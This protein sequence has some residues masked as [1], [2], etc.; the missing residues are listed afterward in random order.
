[1]QILKLA[2]E[3]TKSYNEAKFEF[4][5][6]TNAIV[7]ANGAGKSTILEAIGFALFDSMNYRQADFVREGA[8]T[9]TVTVT[10]LS[11][12]DERRYEITRRCGGSNQYYVFD[13]ELNGKIC[14]G[15]SDV[16]TFLKEHM[17]VDPAADLTALFTDAVGVPQGT[18]TAAFLQAASARKKAFDTLLQ[19]EEYKEAADKLRE[20][21]RILRDQIQT[22]DL[23][24]KEIE[25]RLERL[26]ELQTQVAARAKRLAELE[27]QQS[28]YKTQLDTLQVRIEAESAIQKEIILAQEEGRQLTQRLSSL[29]RE[30]KG[31]REALSEAEQSQQLVL[32]NQ[33]G[34]EAYQ[35]AQNEQTA[36]G[37]QQQERQK[38]EVKQNQ[39]SQVIARVEMEIEV[40]SRTL[41]EIEAAQQLVTDLAEAVQQQEKLEKEQEALERKRIQLTD[42]QRDLP[43][44]EK[45]LSQ[46]QH[47]QNKLETQLAGQ[48]DLAEKR[49]RLNDHLKVQQDRLPQFS[50]AMG[51]YQVEA[52]SLKEQVSSLQNVDTAACPVCE[53]PLSASHRQALMQRNEARLKELRQA[54]ST[55]RKE[56]EEAKTQLEAGQSQ[57][58][59]LDL[60]LR[61]LPRP[62]ELQTVRTEAH[63]CTDHLNRQQSQIETLEGE[64]P[65]LERTQKSLEELGNPRQ[66]QAL[67]LDKISQREQVNQLLGKLSAKKENESK[68]RT[69]VADQLQA[70]SGLDQAIGSV[71]ETLARS[72]SA[73]QAVLAHQQ[74]AASLDLR[75]QNVITLQEEEESLQSKQVETAERLQN[76][77]GQFNDEAFQALQKEAEDIRTEAVST[78]AQ[79]RLLQSDQQRDEAE[80]GR[81]QA[82]EAEQQTIVAQRTKL[83]Y[84][85][86]S[87]E[88]IR[89]YLRQAGPYITRTLIQQVSSGANQIFG[90]LMQDYSRHLSWDEEY[91]IQLEVDGRSRHFPQLSGGEQMSAAL[92]VRLALLREMSNIDIAFFDEPTT[93]LDATRRESLARQILEVKGFQQL[94]VISH[95]DTFEQ[96][97]ENVIRLGE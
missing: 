11:D 57:L 62:E 31:A 7:G 86:D 30:I 38:L 75:K 9:A 83:A 87:L 6:G 44:L 1:M 54:Y 72:Q 71:Q 8:K 77:A 76:L 17:Q 26:P 21:G 55:T 28:Q 3:N 68:N 74:T 20:P 53:Q 23:S 10:I 19:V 39:I 2:L 22:M 56:E 36:L 64:I 13:P 90:D 59:G 61:Q 82:M 33:A 27:E 52:E 29:T 49:Q 43:T 85:A 96:S 34:Y 73:Y 46:L 91:S 32:D 79:S 25:T 63:E 97:I 58:G 88:T 35:Q 42:L 51:Q 93:N 67:A 80:V 45:R 89:T 40:Q 70:F 4:T 69:E 48:A 65:Q 16:L 41:T 12:L 5:P 14:E 94:F 50:H 18:L 92:S 78:Q 81:L 66:R 60:Q 47:R 84:Q 24:L 15:K 95:D 37:K